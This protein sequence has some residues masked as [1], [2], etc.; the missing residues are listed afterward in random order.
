MVPNEPCLSVA[1]AS[2]PKRPAPKCSPS[3]RLDMLLVALLLGVA[4]AVI[5]DTQYGP[6]QGFTR[7]DVNIWLGIPYAAPPGKR[8]LHLLL[9]L[10]SAALSESVLL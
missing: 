8:P 3:F 1:M 2:G 5:V 6:V 4:S 7:D 9:L 10:S